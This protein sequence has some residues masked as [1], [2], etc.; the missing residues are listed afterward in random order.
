MTDIHEHAKRNPQLKT[1]HD[2]STDTCWANF[3]TEDRD[4]RYFN[5]H[6]W[7]SQL[8]KTFREV[9]LMLT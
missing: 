9:K 7:E 8:A 5:T 4:G 3:G 2:A 1:G 6:S